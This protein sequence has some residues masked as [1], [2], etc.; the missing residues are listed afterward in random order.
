[1]NIIFD[2]NKNYDYVKCYQLTDKLRWY[3]IQKEE[4][5]EEKEKTK[6]TK[7]KNTY[8]NSD[9][10]SFIWLSEQNLKQ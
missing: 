6:I 9:Y 8:L 2:K 5:E 7:N 3:L 4:I 1:M 10:D